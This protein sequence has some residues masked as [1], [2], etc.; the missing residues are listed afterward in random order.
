S[1]ATATNLAQEDCKYSRQCQ[2]YDALLLTTESTVTVYGEISVVPEGKLAPGSHEMKVDYWRLIGLA[3]ACGAD[4]IM[5]AESGVDTQ[6]DNRHI[7]MRDETV[8]P[9]TLLQTQ[10]EDAYVSTIFKFSFLGEDAYLTQS[11]QLYLETALPA[12]GDVFCVAQSYRA[13]QSKSRRH[14]SEYTHV[15][16]ECPFITFDELLDRIEDLVCD[17]VERV[18]KSPYKHLLYE[19]NPEFQPPKKPF[20]RMN[21]ADAIVYLKEHDIRKDDGTFCEFGEVSTM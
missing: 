14:L 12:L 9:P 18:L 4:A 5:N 20:K 11:S 16:A 1:L 17:V 7:L 8:T 6:L 15:E 2:T 21:Y 10:V 19:L 3:A 13:E